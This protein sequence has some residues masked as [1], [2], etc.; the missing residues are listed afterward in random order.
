MIGTQ[1]AIATIEENL[2]LVKKDLDKVRRI[3][4]G[5][6]NGF[7]RSILERQ[8]REKK[9]QYDEAIFRLEQIKILAGE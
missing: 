9:E 2:R 4:E 6:P 1:M 3:I 5:C 8:Y 7:C